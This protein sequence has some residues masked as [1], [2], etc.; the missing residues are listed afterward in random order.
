M[1]ILIIFE[2]THANYY[3]ALE[4][5]F[6]NIS[7][8][9]LMIATHNEDTVLKTVSTLS[10]IFF[11]SLFFALFWLTNK[12]WHDSENL[13]STQ[14]ITEF[15]LHNFMAW[16]TTLAIYFSKTVSVLSNM[17]LLDPLSIALFYTSFP[18]YFINYL[19]D[20]WRHVIPYLV[21]RMQENRGF[22]GSASSTE[23]R[24][25]WKE[26]TRRV[27]FWSA[28]STTTTVITSPRAL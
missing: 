18:C 8:L 19:F 24:L 26:L 27:S 6:E 2:D 20:K 15:N 14:W 10:I 3:K 1:C 13:I 23:R 11:S 28:P 5:A 21:R 4:I 25:L 12:R 22:I 17:F 9:G 7:D 16:V